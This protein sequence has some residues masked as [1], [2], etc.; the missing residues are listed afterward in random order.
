M[1]EKK[2]NDEFYDNLYMAIRDAIYEA[3]TRTAINLDIKIRKNGW[4]YEIEVTNKKSP[5]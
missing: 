3:L 2:M 1:S 5:K 4:I